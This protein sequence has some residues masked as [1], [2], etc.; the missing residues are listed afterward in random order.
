M[1]FILRKNP[2]NG[3]LIRQFYGPPYAYCETKDITHCSNNLYVYNIQ[4]TSPYKLYVTTTVATT[5][6]CSNDLVNNFATVA[7]SGMDEINSQE[8]RSTMNM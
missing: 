5:C 3:W 8:T 2:N 1:P 4:S 7:I 6:S